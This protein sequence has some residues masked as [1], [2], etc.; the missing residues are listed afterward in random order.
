MCKF[1]QPVGRAAALARWGYRRSPLGTEQGGA[2]LP[3]PY[4]SRW[5]WE[6]ESC[7]WS[8]CWPADVLDWQINR[9]K[10]DRKGEKPWILHHWSYFFHMQYKHLTSIWGVQWEKKV[11]CVE[12]AWKWWREGIK[13]TRTAE[14]V[15]AHTSK[16]MEEEQKSERGIKNETWF[17]LMFHFLHRSLK[18][19]W[20]VCLFFRIR[21]SQVS[22]PINPFI[23]STL[24]SDQPKEVCTLHPR[25]VN[26]IDQLLVP[27]F[28][29]QS[30][31]LV[32]LFTHIH[33]HTRPHLR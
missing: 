17:T 33:A 32:C 22:W 27:V 3:A 15:A 16:D 4:W 30:G 7:C 9:S 21:M 12:A 2:F 11:E 20:N 19:Q 24:C 5:H 28:R 18:P 29:F 14:T 10:R 6:K 25:E 8:Y 23:L 26:S 13:Y 31:P 1:I